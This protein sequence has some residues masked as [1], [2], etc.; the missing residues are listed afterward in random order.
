MRDP[1]AP[2]YERIKIDELLHEVSLGEAIHQA[3]EGNAPIFRAMIDQAREDASEGLKRM[4]TIDLY[5]QEGI[6]R[7]RSAQAEVRRYFDI[8]R[9]ITMGLNRAETASAILDQSYTQDETVKALKEMM[10]GADAEEVAND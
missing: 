8:L 4:V 7:M 3:L 2:S 1:D 10:Y 9:W 6:D 5:T